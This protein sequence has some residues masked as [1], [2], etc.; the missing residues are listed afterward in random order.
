MAHQP[1]A[2]VGSRIPQDWEEEI[3]VIA[4]STGRKPS[5]IL[6]EAIAQ[7]LGK[8]NPEAIKNTLDGHSLRIADLEQKLSKLTKLLTS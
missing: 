3:K 8:A 5:E 1:M 4:N 6:R 2:S 7:Y